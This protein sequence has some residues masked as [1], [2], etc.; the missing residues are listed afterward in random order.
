MKKLF[1]IS[2]FLFSLLSYGQNE[3]S[4]DIIGKWIC[5][6]AHSTVETSDVRIE[7]YLTLFSQSEFKFT[8]DEIFTL[9]KLNSDDYEKSETLIESY[10]KFN[11]LNQVIVDYKNPST[12]LKIIIEQKNNETYFLLFDK[13]LSLKMKKL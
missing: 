2:S 3:E 13:A 1:I 9:K 6:D 4:L 5:T 8:E 11:K 12:I 7:K 10:W